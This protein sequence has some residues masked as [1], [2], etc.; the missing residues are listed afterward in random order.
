MIA[1]IESL[2]IESN[3]VIKGLGTLPPNGET[4]EQLGNHWAGRYIIV[5][6]MDKPH[7]FMAKLSG[8]LIIRA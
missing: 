6:L 1:R 5:L 4:Y 2:K 8:Q 7:G 3:L